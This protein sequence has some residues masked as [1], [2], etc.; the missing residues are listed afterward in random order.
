VDMNFA[1]SAWN[2][3][4]VF[5]DN[6]FSSA[7]GDMVWHFGRSTKSNKTWSRSRKIDFCCYCCSC[8]PM[9]SRGCK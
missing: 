7:G 4:T 3:F 8:R 5:P 9:W 6:T 2:V 1:V